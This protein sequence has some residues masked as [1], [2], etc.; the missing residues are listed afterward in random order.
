MPSLLFRQH[1]RHPK[2]DSGTGSVQKT[3][4]FK[5]TRLTNTKQEK[6]QEAKRPNP[7]PSQP[8][9]PSHPLGRLHTKPFSQTELRP[10]KPR[11]K[12]LSAYATASPSKA[13]MW[14]DGGGGSS[15]G[16][17]SHSGGG[18][19]GSGGG[20]V[21]DHS[22]EKMALPAR[23]LFVGA[24]IKPGWGESDNTLHLSREAWARCSCMAYAMDTK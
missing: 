10:P 18:G 14:R 2:R 23:A 22:S 24:Q 16:G 9:S 11:P 13:P 3:S 20:D 21:G 7:A 12:S 4:I 1:V 19:G 5:H 8:P 17:G 15:R 6:R